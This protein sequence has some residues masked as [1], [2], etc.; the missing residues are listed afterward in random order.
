MRS[1]LIRWASGAVELYD[2]EN[3]LNG[4]STWP[5]TRRAPRVRDR[6]ALVALPRL[7]ASD[8]A[9]PLLAFFQG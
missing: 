9:A 2:L 8:C 1:K 6:L 3:D 5:S 4:L 7:V